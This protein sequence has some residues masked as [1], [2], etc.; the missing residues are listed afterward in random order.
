MFVSRRAYREVCSERD[1]LREQNDRI[2]VELLSVT[3]VAHGL[4]EQRRK[5]KKADPMP[6]SLRELI[7]GFES[8]AARREVE[9]QSF[10]LKRQGKT[11]GQIEA[12]LKESL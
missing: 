2:L 6:A 9:R 1:R 11:W 10:Q 5:E 3:R 8:Q 7:A 12:K 4:P